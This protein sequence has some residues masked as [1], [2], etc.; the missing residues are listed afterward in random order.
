VVTQSLGHEVLSLNGEPAA[1]VYARLLESS[2]EMLNDK[3]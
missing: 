2:R 1:D 3:H